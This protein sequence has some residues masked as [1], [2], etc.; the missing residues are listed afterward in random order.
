MEIWQNLEKTQ[1]RLRFSSPK[2]CGR[3]ITIKYLEQ[4]VC[5]VGAKPVAKTTTKL[6]N[7]EIT[8]TLDGIPRAVSLGGGFRSTD[9]TCTFNAMKLSLV[10]VAAYLRLKGILHWIQKLVELLSARLGTS[11]KSP[12]R[13]LIFGRSKRDA[14]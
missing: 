5:A 1:H 2:I 10:E 7:C 8:R 14:S 6:R 11:G 12:L 13:F 3:K 4:I 9:V